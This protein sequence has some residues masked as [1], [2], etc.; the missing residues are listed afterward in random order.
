MLS[1]EGA[2]AGGGGHRA[3]AGGPGG[4]RRSDQPP[5]GMR[6]QMSGPGSHT[7]KRFRPCDK[8]K[9]DVGAGK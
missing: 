8:R 7:G 4:P 3:P 2:G 5:R 6:I 9:L 1:A